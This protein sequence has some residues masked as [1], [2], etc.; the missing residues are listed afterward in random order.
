MPN[1]PAFHTAWRAKDAN[2]ERACAVRVRMPRPIKC[3]KYTAS[4]GQCVQRRFYTLGMAS[5]QQSRQLDLVR[6]MLQRS[7]VAL[8]IVPQ[9]R[10][11]TVT[12][13]KAYAVMMH[14]AQQQFA[15]GTS[16]EE[17]FAAPLGA[18]LRGFGATSSI[19]SDV[20]KYIDQ[21]QSTR[22]EWRPLSRTE[23][24]QMQ[25]LLEG[26]SG[27]AT[28]LVDSVEITDEVRMF[29]LLSEARLY[30]RG[31][32][33]WVTWFYPPTISAEIVNP[34]RWA[35][36][37]IEVMTELNTYAAVAL[38]DIC[39]RYRDNPGGVTSRQHWSWWVDV[40]RGSAGSKQRAWR[41]FK[42]EFVMPAVKEIND[43]G[44]IEVELIEFRRGREVDQVQFGVRKS[45]RR[46]AKL[47]PVPPDVTNLLRGAKLGIRDSEIEA[48]EAK[49]G[50]EAVSEGL[51]R[52]E[53]HMR[54]AE[55]QHVVKRA[56]YLT[57][58]IMNYTKEQTGSSNDQVPEEI[59]QQS[60][61]PPVSLGELQESEK[62]TKL[63]LVR[64]IFESLEEDERQTWVQ[65][66][67]E[68]K[69]SEVGLQSASVIRRL[70]AGE[71]QS[72]LVR[73]MVLRYYAVSRFGPDWATTP[74]SVFDT[75]VS[76]S[77]TK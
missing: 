62:K 2:S 69:S 49:Y 72:P 5:N 35:Q 67:R 70:D 11:L 34:S 50:Q 60:T 68:A 74:A 61:K 32:E 18:I 37:D 77:A 59:Q 7:V 16:Q 45:E 41:K 6:G 48:L 31:G 9:N 51:E 23:E 4:L 29:N 26:S 3:P 44:D 53:T 25:L 33:N 42:N 47:A 8:A 71:W 20:K 64:T 21:M 1:C 15:R 39:A 58:I 73:D 56:A 13:R 63:A 43:A 76:Q 66:L 46:R 12:G 36:T 57:T 27:E 55:G 28:N 30:K 19:T 38:Y 17:G 65:R 40:L 52:F 14:L 75:A 24:L 54:G 10:S 22:I